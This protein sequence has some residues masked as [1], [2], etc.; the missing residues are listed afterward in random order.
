MNHR[1]RII[2]LNDN[3]RYSFPMH[4]LVTA[5][6]SGSIRKH[7]LKPASKQMIGHESLRQCQLVPV[8]GPEDSLVGSF[9]LHFA[10]MG[11]AAVCPRKVDVP[12]ST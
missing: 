10:A 8:Q 4:F 3:W 1:D 5:I 6:R 7:W 9:S 2:K 12:V 11:A